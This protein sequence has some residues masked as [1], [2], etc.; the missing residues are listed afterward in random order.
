[1]RVLLRS[2]AVLVSA[3]GVALTAQACDPEKA[4]L[5]VFEKQGLTLLRPARSY[6][7]VGGLVIQ[8]RSGQPRYIDPLDDV[9]S[10]DEPA[11][12]FDAVVLA[13]TQKRATKLGTALGLVQQLVTIP[14]GLQFNSSRDVTLSQV[15]TGGVRIKD[16]TLETLIKQKQTA[17]KL[18]EH[19][20][21]NLKRKAYIVQEVYLSASL[22]LAATTATS[23]GVTLG[24]DAELPSCDI[25]A[26][27]KDETGQEGAKPK[28]GEKPKEGE[29]A[30]DGEKPKEGEKAKDPEKPKDGEKPGT[31]K[32]EAKVAETAKSTADEVKAPEKPSASIGLCYANQGKTVLSF[33]SA[34]PLP[35]AV[36]LAEIE[37][38]GKDLKIKI[39]DFKFSGSLGTSE[40]ERTTALP[41]GGPQFKGVVFGDR[42][43]PKE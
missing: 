34:K 22:N 24:K 11:V 23:L 7:Q 43:L 16:K 27:V 26:S 13:E 25:A 12:D 29:K 33:K 37:L 8:P 35:F 3:L 18:F 38:V 1:M 10:V 36:R 39:G 28:D 15:D 40:I 30:K 17:A 41:E 14:L 9:A 42:G 4:A 2:V 32:H 19:L 20:A 21:P 6:I 5:T 31:A